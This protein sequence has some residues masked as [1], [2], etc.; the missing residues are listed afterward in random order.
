[1]KWV[2]CGNIV[3]ISDANVKYDEITWRIVIIIIHY[4]DVIMGAIA[5]QITSLTIVYSTVYSG[6]DKKKTHQSSAS[7]SFVREIHRR[8]VNSPHKWPVT[9]K[10]FP[11]DDV[12]IRI[13][14]LFE[15]SQGSVLLMCHIFCKISTPYP[16]QIGRYFA[17]DNF[18]V[19]S[20]HGNARILNRVPTKHISKCPID[21]FSTSVQITVW[22]RTKEKPLAGPI[23][24]WCCLLKL[25]SPMG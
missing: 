25:K 4:N 12:I 2:C 18:S 8:P 23:Q 9:R 5:S 17:D 11:F 10:M 16:R 24:W 3:L 13:F 22:L 21:S 14:V 15:L 1:M 7:L 6:A 20:F 19:I